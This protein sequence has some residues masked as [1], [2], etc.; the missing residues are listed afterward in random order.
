MARSVWKGNLSVGLVH[1]PVAL[2]KATDDA[3]KGTHKRWLH[4][5]CGTPINQKKICSKCLIDVE[6]AN[7]V[8]GVEQEDGSYVILT[9]DEIG[10]MRAPTTDTI[11]VEAFVP[12]DS[13]DPVYVDSTYY[14]SVVKPTP[15]FA[16]LRDAMRSKE[17][18][19]TGRFSI[20]GRERLVSVRPLG[21]ILAL[22]LLRTSN[23]VRAIEEL[24]HF[25]SLT[26]PV[27]QK[28][29][30][31]ANQLV[32]MY[33]GVFNP[34]ANEDRYKIA[35]DALVAAKKS[36]QLISSGVPYVPTPPMDLMAAITASL[37][38]RQPAKKEKGKKKVA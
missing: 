26:T 2:Y 28:Q 12:A 31:L 27:D 29:L 38:L 6:M 7:I 11:L 36:G 14:L 30:T 23:E 3:A 19:M 1:V 25:V 4:D 21:P 34:V 20:Y 32:T 5:A 22:E 17:M 9:K 24:P 8:D 37:A 18:V 35:F 16:L 33:A 15:G 13:I 10:G